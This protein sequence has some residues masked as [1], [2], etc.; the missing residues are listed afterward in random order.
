MKSPLGVRLSKDSSSWP[1]ATPGIGRTNTLSIQLKTVVLAAMPIAS[2]STATSVKPG[3]FSDILRAN[4]KSCAN[5]RMRSSSRNE[6]SVPQ[7][8]CHQWDKPPACPSERSSDVFPLCLFAECIFPQGS[9]FTGSGR[10]TVRTWDSPAATGQVRPLHVLS[11]E[12][13][14]QRVAQPRHRVPHIHPRIAERLHRAIPLHAVDPSRI[15]PQADQPRLKIRHVLRWNHVE[16]HADCQNRALRH[17]RI[18]R[19]HGASL[20]GLYI[21]VHGMVTA[22]AVEVPGLRPVR[23]RRV[24]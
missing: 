4:R 15:E 5:V 13:R 17:L 1:F 12:L 11:R 6:A 14:L 9:G 23:V 7:S 22:V 21:L 19:K 24:D 2:V 3:L 20:P 8:R 18:G 16:L 10:G